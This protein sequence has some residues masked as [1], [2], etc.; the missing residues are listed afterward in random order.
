MCYSAIVQ[1]DAKKLGI[2]F[3]ARVQYDLFEELFSRRL[4]GEKISINKAMEYPFTHG[5]TSEIEGKIADKIHRWHES[6]IPELETALAA[7]KVRLAEAEKALAAKPTKKA[8]N[9][10][11]I[12]RRK[13]E[14]LELDFKRHR[15]PEYVVE[16]ERRI[17]PLQYMSMVGLDEN[18]ELVARPVR[19]LM[20]PRGQSPDFDRKYNGCYNAR[21]DSLGSVPWWKESFG[22]RHG[23]IVVRKFFENVAVTDY[24]KKFKLVG[25]PSKNIVLSF[26]PETGE[27]MLIP[28]L[29]DAWTDGREIL[30][31]AAL[32]T[33][34][35]A[36][37]IAETG[38]NRMPIFLTDE[39]AQKWLRPG[40]RPKDHWMDILKDRRSPFYRHEVVPA[41]S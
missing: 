32:I 16:W 37:E 13:I 19:Y 34:D 18:G 33:D 29:W 35:P 41:A 4:A 8:L 2:R 22:R 20:R 38:H 27:D 21:L 26:E 23:L 28:T 39:A 31:S 17:F 7:Q 25:E 11:G 15:T 30:Y 5:A 9:E 24:S 12:A 36:P 14:K 40:D 1:Q 6:Q 10:Q 3:Q